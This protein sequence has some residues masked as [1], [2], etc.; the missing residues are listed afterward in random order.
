[1]TY[2]NKISCVYTTDY[3]LAIQRND[4]LIQ[5]AKC[6]SFEN[7]M[8]SERKSHERWHIVG[9]HLYVM[10]R[11]GKSIKTES[12]LVITEDWGKGE[13]VETANGYGFFCRDGR[14]KCP[15]RRFVVAQLW[16][17]T[18]SQWIMH[19]KYWIFWHM[20]YDKAIVTKTQYTIE[21][22]WIL[23]NSC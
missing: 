22:V 19:F 1:M 15:G 8:L 21:W 12:S 23:E 9:F 4:I 16:K 5:V 20:N 13:K 6:M 3:Y 17:Y 11:I 7:N 14:W 18:K 2:P 10:S